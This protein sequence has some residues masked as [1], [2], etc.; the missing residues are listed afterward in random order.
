MIELTR[1]HARQLRTVLRKSLPTGCTRFY[2][3]P[4]SLTGSETGLR[5]RV[6]NPEVAVEWQIPGSWMAD[7]IT[8]PSSALAD[9]EG[10]RDDGVTLAAKNKEVIHAEW[11][12]GSVPQSRDYTAIDLEKLPP[13]PEEPDVFV[14][15]ALARLKMLDDAAQTAAK[16]SNRFAVTK[17]QLR[18]GAG[19]IVATDSRQLLL[20]RGFEFPFKDDILVPAIAAFGCKELH[21][22]EEV[23]SAVAVSV[24][25]RTA[26]KIGWCAAVVESGWVTIQLFRERRSNQAE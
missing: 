9:F 4:I 19:E 20:Q 18:G 26:G 2:H 8:L 10:R 23:A 25:I 5:I 24:A 16:E 12:D 7:T 3:P 22:E 13:F 6:H 14:P 15:Q 21:G 11:C 1:A 17:L